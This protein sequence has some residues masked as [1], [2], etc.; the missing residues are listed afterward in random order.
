MKKENFVILAH[1]RSGSTTLFHIFENQ[2]VKIFCEPFNKDST[3]KYL[4]H[5]NENDFDSALEIILN[6]Y[7][8]FKHL[9]GFSSIEQNKYIKEKCETIFLYRENLLNA[10]VSQTLAFATNVWMKSQK[11]SEYGK[12][13]ININ[14][15]AV[16][17]SIE[18]FRR[19]QELKD[20]KCFCISYEELYYS[21]N[22]KQKEIIEEMFNFVGCK[23]INH[24]S[25][26]NLLNVENNKINP[27][28]WSDIIS[29]WDEIVE[30]VTLP[31]I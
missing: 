30:K 4:S 5:W 14:P 11:K 7:K 23:I 9:F 25:I 2:G 18:Y 1:A 6:E 3:T 21:D 19:F 8:G 24:K 20:D 28:N 29:N 22:N 16:K 10:A 15:Y 26:E 31:K 27:E 13:K 12:E 17:T